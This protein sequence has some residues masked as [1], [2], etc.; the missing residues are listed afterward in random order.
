MQ[1][2]KGLQVDIFVLPRGHFQFEE[3]N[4]LF[5]DVV[6]LVFVLTIKVDIDEQVTSTSCYLLF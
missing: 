5:K 3:L 6:V 4:D 1:L 2:L